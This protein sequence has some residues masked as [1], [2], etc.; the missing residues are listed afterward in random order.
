[1]LFTMVVWMVYHDTLIEVVCYDVVYA[2]GVSVAHNIMRIG[3]KGLHDNNCK[4][5]VKVGVSCM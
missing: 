2:K 5:P 1:M 3:K 4:C